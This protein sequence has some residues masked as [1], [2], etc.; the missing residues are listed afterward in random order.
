[1]ALTKVW[2]DESNDECVSCGACEAT[3]DAVFSVPEKMQVKEGRCRLF[4]LRKRNQGRCRQL[5]G[6]RD[7]V[8]VIIRGARRP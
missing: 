1:M 8:R 4:R 6:R 7:Q 2:L 5:P 3:C